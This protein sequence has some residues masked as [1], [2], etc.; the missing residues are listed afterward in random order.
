[1]N[2]ISQYLSDGP[3]PLDAAP[4]RARQ[5]MLRTLCLALV[6]GLAVLTAGVVCTVEF[7]A[8][9]PADQRQ[10][11]PAAGGARRHRRRGRR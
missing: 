9:R 8:G 3:H 4:M 7:R 2:R 6:G 5:A 1:M 11:G 10:R